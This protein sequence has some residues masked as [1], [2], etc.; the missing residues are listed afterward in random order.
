MAWAQVPAS[1]EGEPLAL[2]PAMTEQV[3][4]VNRVEPPQAGA[5]WQSAPG[6]TAWGLAALLQAPAA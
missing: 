3:K 1:V 6:L 4:R 5:E 2:A